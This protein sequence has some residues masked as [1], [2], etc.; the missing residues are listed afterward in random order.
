MVK[1]RMIEANSEMEKLFKNRIIDGEEPIELVEF[2]EVWRNKLNILHGLENKRNKMNGH[3]M[4]QYYLLIFS[5][6]FVLYDFMYPGPVM[7]LHDNAIHLYLC[8]WILT[9]IAVMFLI[10]NYRRYH[11]LDKALKENKK[12]VVKVNSNEATEKDLQVYRIRIIQDESM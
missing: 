7:I 9:L 3:I 12:D 8:G 10:L 6:F 1:Q 5:I 4:F 11:D 2:G